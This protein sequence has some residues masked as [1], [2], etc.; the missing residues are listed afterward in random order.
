MFVGSVMLMKALHH[1]TTKLIKSNQGTATCITNGYGLH[2]KCFV[3]CVSSMASPTLSYILFLIIIPWLL[4]V[5]YR[6]TTQIPTFFT[7][8]TW[9]HTNV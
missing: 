1:N 4:W 3:G 7:H 5:F 8:I 6:P 9:I 2:L